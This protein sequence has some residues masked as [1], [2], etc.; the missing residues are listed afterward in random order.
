MQTNSSRV[1]WVYLN[2]SQ[3][4]KRWKE[5]II[6]VFL[7]LPTPLLVSSQLGGEDGTM[8]IG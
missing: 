3:R 2:L 5:E 8:A 1:V 4:Q 6:L 7:I